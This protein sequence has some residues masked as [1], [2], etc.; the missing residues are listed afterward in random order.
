MGYY[1][2]LKSVSLDK[3][4]DKLEAAD[5]LPGRILLKEKLDK[6]FGYFKSIGIKNVAGLQQMLKKKDSIASILKVDLF[7]EE[8]LRVLLRE[9]NSIHPKPNNLKDFT[10]IS[11][12]TFSALEKVGI[13]TTVD[14]Y[15]KI[16]SP[17][18]RTMLAEGTGLSPEQI[19]ELTRLTDLSRI[20][21]VG[22]MFARVLYETGYDTAEKVA[23][24]DYAEL[25]RRI[26]ELNIKRHLFRGNIG[27]N[28]VKLCVN[29]AKE[30]SIDILF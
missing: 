13:K 14:L 16:I 25:H 19:M 24:A 11:S 26:T 20:R 12:D 1:I 28:D 30:L 2:D 4:R 18:E 21:W 3:Y 5:L 7:T 15:A 8:Y 22:A 9:I 6:R 10:G 27:L 23:K 29:A 17:L